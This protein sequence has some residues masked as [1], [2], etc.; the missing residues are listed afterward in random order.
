MVARTF[1]PGERPQRARPLPLRSALHLF[2]IFS[3]LRAQ[4]V[5]PAE[6]LLIGKMKIEMEEAPRSPW[7]AVRALQ[8]ICRCHI[9]EEAKHGILSSVG[10]RE[11]WYV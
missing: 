9:A 3:L 6:S 8:F 10:K 11:I 1:Q 5:S 7:D 2:A 4:N